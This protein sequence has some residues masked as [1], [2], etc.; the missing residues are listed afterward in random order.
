MLSFTEQQ[1]LTYLSSVNKTISD[2]PKKKSF[3]CLDSD[4]NYVALPSQST[5]STCM[6]GGDGSDLQ[7]PLTSCK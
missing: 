2:I 4:I 6:A 1:P 7:L 3:L 5:Q